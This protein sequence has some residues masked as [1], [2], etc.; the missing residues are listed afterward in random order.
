MDTTLE[1][2]EILLVEDNE[3]DA[4]LTMRALKRNN[5]ANGLLHL[6][7]G[8]EALDFIFGEGTHAGREVEHR[9]QVIVLDINMPRVSGLEVLRRLKADER[10]CHIPVVVLTSTKDDPIMKHCYE[11]GVNS[12]VVKPV[13]F[14]AFFK[15]ISALGFFWMIVNQV[16]KGSVTA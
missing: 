11:L 5:L 6:R 15:E 16:D 2:V 8:A 1:G 7:D 9:L 13:A 14:D 12:Y 10:T 3:H 4:E